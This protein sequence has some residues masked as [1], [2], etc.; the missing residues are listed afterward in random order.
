MKYWKFMRKLGK[1]FIH[2]E[3]YILKIMNKTDKA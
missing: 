2:L 3:E 1:Y